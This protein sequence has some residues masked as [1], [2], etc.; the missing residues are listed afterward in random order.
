MALV[1]ECE[2]TTLFD[3]KVRKEGSHDTPF[4]TSTI[5]ENRR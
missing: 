2:N 1:T 3:R 5:Q 4:F